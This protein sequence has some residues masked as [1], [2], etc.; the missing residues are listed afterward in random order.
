MLIRTPNHNNLDLKKKYLVSLLMRIWPTYTFLDVLKLIDGL[1]AGSYLNALL[2]L[3]VCTVLKLDFVVTAIVVSLVFLLSSIA[4]FYGVVFHKLTKLLGILSPYLL[5]I[6]LLFLVQLLYIVVISVSTEPF[7][8][9]FVLG[10]LIM[11]E[12]CEYHFRRWYAVKMETRSGVLIPPNE[13]AFFIAFRYYAKKLGVD[14]SLRQSDED[15]HDDPIYKEVK[16][17]IKQNMEKLQSK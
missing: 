6:S 16:A 8:Y 1:K 7:K 17:Y 9:F 3:Q 5:H 12:L 13:M 2:V 4:T 11:L 10:I 15:F 14:P